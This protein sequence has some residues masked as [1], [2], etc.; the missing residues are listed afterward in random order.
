MIL[1]KYSFGIGDRFGHQGKAQL[2]G[3]MQAKEAGIDITPVWNKSNREHSIIGTKPADVRREADEAVA[4]CGWKGPYLVDADH[5]GLSNVDAFLDASDFFTLDVADFIGQKAS[6]A[7]VSAFAAQHKALIGTVQIPGIEKAFEVSE[8]ALKTIASKYLVAVKEAGK[9]YRHIASEK[10][11]DNF[12][13]E[14]SMDETDTPQT[15]VEMLVILAA[16]A[17][18]GIPAQTIAPKFSGRFNKGVDYVG[19]VDEFAAEFE[20]DLAVIRFAVEE[21]S[22]PA[23]L[24]LSVHSGS[25][26]FSI[27]EPIQKAMKAFDTGLHLKTAGTTWLEELIGLA[28]AGGDGLAIAK[29]VYAT[30][31]GRMDELC[32]PYATVIDINAE[33][34]PHLEEIMSWDGELFARALRHDPFCA[35]YRPNLRQ[36]LHVAYKVAAEMGPRFIGAL[37]Q[38]GDVIAEQ[39]TTNI[40]DRHI[41]PLFLDE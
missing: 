32:G 18:E 11:A 29:E 5:I 28:L 8:S 13:T 4:G 27:Y 37:E 1:G 36:L 15:P 34:L 17:D 6:D 30:A 38:Y 2:A 3:L 21:F 12:I 39:V 40:F 25:D 31:L 19:D 16:I 23:N 24:K 9:I 20:A 10:G 22:L 26:K 33:K 7:D 14:V 35:S 41:R